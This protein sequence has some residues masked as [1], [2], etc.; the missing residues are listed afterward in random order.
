V[1]ESGEVSGADEVGT[2]RGRLWR[3][4]LGCGLA[5]VVSAPIGWVVTDVL[6][7]DNDFCNACHLEPGLPL[8]REVRRD[9]DAPTPASLAGLHGAAAVAANDGERAFRCIDCHGGTSPIGRARVKALAAKDAFWY[10]TGR[11][12]E[13]DGM[14][15]P[16]WDEDC[17]KC[18]ARFDEAAAPPWQSPRFH[19]LPVH[20]VRLGVDCVECHDV[21]ASGGSPQSHFLRAAWVRSQCARCH[22][23]FEDTQG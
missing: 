9:F 12:E 18:H 17:R 19:Q 16:L 2:G 7:R 20:N 8:H 4:L 15:W 14:R 3:L 10:V 6:E 5:G 21:H 1:S 23:E 13:P 11:F 22:A